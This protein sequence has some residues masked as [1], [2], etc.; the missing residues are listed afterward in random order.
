MLKHSCS[1]AGDQ[2]SYQ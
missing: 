2:K 1:K